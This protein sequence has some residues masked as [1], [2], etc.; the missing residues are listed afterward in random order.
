[1]LIQRPQRCRVHLDVRNNRSIISILTLSVIAQQ[2]IDLQEDTQV[3]VY[4]HIGYY[5]ME[6]TC[7]ILNRLLS[8]CIF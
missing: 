3:C 2:G 8:V 1:M 7:P 5:Y 6:G 4:R